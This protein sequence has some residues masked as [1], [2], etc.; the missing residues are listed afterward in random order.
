MFANA[1]VRLAVCTRACA[2]VRV[3]RVTSHAPLSPPLCEL[4]KEE[5]RRGCQ[6]SFVRRGLE[7]QGVFCYCFL[8]TVTRDASVL[9]RCE[10]R[11]CTANRKLV[12]RVKLKPVGGN[13]LVKSVPG[14]PGFSPALPPFSRF[15]SCSGSRDKSHDYRESS[16]RYRPPKKIA[17]RIC[18]YG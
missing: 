13:A 8:C 7:I 18:I 15:A 9:S 2:R 16:S 1:D 5:R 11:S 14:T 10:E 3:P 4:E 12:G 17:S 6:D